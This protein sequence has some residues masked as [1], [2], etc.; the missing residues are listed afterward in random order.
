LVFEHSPARVEEFL[1]SR[2]FRFA[3]RC[4][5]NPSLDAI[6]VEVPARF[7]AERVL[8]GRTSL[9]QMENLKRAAR[10]EGMQV[11]F[12][13]TSHDRDDL[14]GGLRFLLRKVVADAAI[15]CFVSLPSPEVA[16]V[17]LDVGDPG[18][19]S[20]QL[21]GEVIEYLEALGVSLGKLT[22][23][24]AVT[25]LP[26]KIA[27]LR[28]VKLLAPVAVSVLSEA[29]MRE[30]FSVPPGKWLR[31]KL[32][33][34]RKEG[35]LIWRNDDRYVCT[36]RGLEVVPSIRTRTGTDVVRALALA[37]RRWNYE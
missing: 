11:E 35:F 2:R 1:K 22:V 31:S 33:G 10:S 6:V 3:A 32:D 26:T 20:D 37:R 28:Q 25:D 4:V 21:K 34:L 14:E 30:S 15:D 23:L 19:V 8:Y 13:V 27:I 24:G 9:R 7:V 29:L 17:W 36:E 5:F 16:H 12:L 18:R